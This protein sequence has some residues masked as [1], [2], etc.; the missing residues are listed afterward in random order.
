[1]R[2]LLRKRSI[3]NLGEEITKTG[4]HIK[5]MHLLKHRF[6]IELDLNEHVVEVA[7]SAD[8]LDSEGHLLVYH[9]IACICDAVR[10]CS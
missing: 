4:I 2:D 9:I 7:L 3:D 5:R 10:H 1:M 8:L 6:L